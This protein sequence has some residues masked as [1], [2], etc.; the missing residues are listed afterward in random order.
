MKLNF[1][2][3]T[4]AFFLK[5]IHRMK[6]NI[7]TKILSKSG[8]FIF[9]SIIMTAIFFLP[10]DQAKAAAAACMCAVILDTLLLFIIKYTV[11]RHRP[12]EPTGLRYRYDPY[13]FPSGHASRLAAMC[14]CCRSI[15]IVM[16]VLIGL[17]LACT[18]CRMAEKRHYFSDCIVGIFVGILCGVLVTWA[19]QNSIIPV[20]YILYLFGLI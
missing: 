9:C 15:P 7:I 6:S 11:R 1:I 16:S 18:F 5:L 17:C 13:S 3:K 2:R 20:H 14:A 19:V 10:Y 12:I 4:D 8:S